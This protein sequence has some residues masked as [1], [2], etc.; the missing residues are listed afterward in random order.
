MVDGS[1]D[2]SSRAAQATDPEALALGRKIRELRTGSG[3]TLGAL[4]GMIGTSQSL[5]SQVERGMA[6]P[7]LTTL[8]AIAGAL[9][10]PV[11]ALFLGDDEASMGET[12]SAGRRLVVRSWERKRLPAHDSGTIRLLTPDRNREIGFIE[13]EVAAHSAAPPEREPPASHA[14][15]EN[16]I[17]TF[18][19]IV[20]VIDGEEFTLHQG[21]SI[22][23]D[24]SREHR[25]VNRTSE[26]AVVVAAMSGQSF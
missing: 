20:Y 10:V 14:G 19:K 4:A 26:R 3:L 21:D 17:C 16:A 23:F 5:I 25:V 15:E 22:S 6:S 18:G 2:R 13:F 12:D 24:S 11:A 8:R 1:R 7:S 9:E